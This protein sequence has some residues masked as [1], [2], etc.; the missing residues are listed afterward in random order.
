MDLPKRKSARIPNYDYSTP[1]YYFV[2]ICTENKKCIFG[3]PENL[4]YCGKIAEACIL[5]IPGIMP[6]ILIDK[7]VVMPNHIHAIIVI[8]AN[9]PDDCRKSITQIIG[10]YKGA[11]TKMI[12]SKEPNKT[13]WQRSFHDHIIRDQKQYELIWTYIENN[14]IKWEEDCFYMNDNM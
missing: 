3:K 13:I 9:I 6:G 7:Y 11:V 12:R 2:T 4:N 14:P 5:K 8:E 1:N 10:Q